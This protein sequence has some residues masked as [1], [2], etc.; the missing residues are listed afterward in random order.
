MASSFLRLGRHYASG[1]QGRGGAKRDAGCARRAD[2]ISTS[3]TWRNV[4][5]PLLY[6]FAL[7]A[8][9]LGLRGML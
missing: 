8:R 2:P 4:S 7:G 5:D 9:A 3:H 6:R 1:L